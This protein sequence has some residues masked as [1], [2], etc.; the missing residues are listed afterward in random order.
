[1]HEREKLPPDRTL[2]KHRQAGAHRQRWGVEGRGYERQKSCCHACE[3]QKC[4]RILP[5]KLR[6]VLIGLVAVPVQPDRRAVLKHA[7]EGRI[8]INVF[9]AVARKQPELIALYEGIAQDE[10]VGR[11][12]LV[13]FE[14]RHSQ[15]AGDDASAEPGI[16]FQ[17]EDILAG[18][19]QI[20][21]GY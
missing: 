7:N 17:N 20:G 1:M 11:R 19:R 10:D 21:G 9:Q 16:S 8:R 6:D 14:S 18:G 12:V 4:I 3:F 15:F 2:I 5:R 13:M